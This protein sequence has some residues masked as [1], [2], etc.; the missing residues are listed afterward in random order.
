MS[1]WF[2]G[3]EEWV[4]FAGI[5]KR[6]INS[7]ELKETIINSFKDEYLTFYAMYEFTVEYRNK[8]LNIWCKFSV[9]FEDL[10]LRTETLGSLSKKSYFRVGTL[11]DKKSHE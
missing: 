3:V 4:I 10:I 1:K 6:E 9:N 5:M 8:K 11:I 2:F 7:K